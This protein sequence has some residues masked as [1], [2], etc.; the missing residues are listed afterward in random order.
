MLDLIERLSGTRVMLA[1]VV[2]SLLASVALFQLGP[3]AEL[4]RAAGGELPE[5]RF[6]AGAA[7]IGE[8]LQRL[9][10]DGRRRYGVFQALDLVNALLTMVALVLLTA[11]A[12]RGAFP[13]RRRW[14]A[15]AWLPLAMFVAEGTEN[16]LLMQLA[17]ASPQ[18][19]A[20]GATGFVGG[21]VPALAAATSWVVSA[22]LVLGGASFG[23]ALLLL[24]AW[25]L[26]AVS[27]R[28]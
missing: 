9:G 25:G 2:V 3:Y 13:G 24:A 19:W 11:R 22:K 16:L 7:D 6:R 23:V 28:A 5:E 14:Q 8:R 20:A 15:L 17:Q 27:A 18:A 12:A 1:A 4:R 10:D 21:G 26:R